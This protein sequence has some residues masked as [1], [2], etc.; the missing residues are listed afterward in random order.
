MKLEKNGETI[1]LTNPSHIDAYKSAGWVEAADK[2]K[3]AKK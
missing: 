2:K 3:P 1:E